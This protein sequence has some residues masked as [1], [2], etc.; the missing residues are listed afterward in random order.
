MP[1]IDTENQFMEDLNLGNLLDTFGQ[2]NR[3]KLFPYFTIC[4][5][6]FPSA[7]KLSLPVDESK[8]V[9]VTILE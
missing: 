7:L 1:Q 2:N 4:F 3:F 5:G 9:I 6:A 8:D